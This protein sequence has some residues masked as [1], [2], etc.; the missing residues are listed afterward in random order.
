MTSA[1][2]TTTETRPAEHASTW[3]RSALAAFADGLDRAERD[4]A[5]AV[6]IASVL[7]DAVAAADRESARRKDSILDASL[8]TLANARAES[9][10]DLRAVARALYPDDAD[11]ASISADELAQQATRLHELCAHEHAE[12]VTL[13][14]E[15]ARLNEARADANARAEAAWKQADRMTGACDLLRSEVSDLRAALA[16]SAKA[17]ENDGDLRAVEP[18]TQSAPLRVGDRVRLRDAV[19]EDVVGP[20]VIIVSIACENDAPTV[21]C[22]TVGTIAGRVRA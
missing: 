7:R 21:R 1:S 15:V 13:T 12:N 14:A 17:N 3:A 16:L 2:T 5:S 6:T 11:S 19:V 18:I 8:A 4:R 10:R 20:S 9:L 22:M